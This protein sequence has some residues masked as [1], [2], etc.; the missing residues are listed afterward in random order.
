MPA[1][2]GPLF[3]KSDIIF[4][5]KS[6]CLP[7]AASISEPVIP[8]S[9]FQ[10]IIQCQLVPLEG[11]KPAM[12]SAIFCDAEL[13]Q[14]V[15]GQAGINSYLEG[16]PGR[17]MMALKSVLGSPLMED[18]TVVFNDYISYSQILGHFVKHLK[19]AAEKSCRA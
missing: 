15:F 7:I 4:E 11:S 14:W 10:L 8:L 18:K 12:R 9:V 1:K 17:L 6:S 5:E 16:N 3:L 19:L 2:I 13:K